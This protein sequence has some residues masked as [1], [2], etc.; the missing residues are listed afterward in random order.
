MS[1]GKRL[2]KRS[3]IGTRVCA[4]GQDGK[5]YSGV[6]HAVKTPASAASESGLSITPKTRYSVR[7]DSVPGGRPPSPSTEYSD[8]DLIGPGFGSVTSARLVPGQK[9]YLTY[10]GREIHAE[11]TQHR[12]HQDEVDVIIAPNG[13]ET[14]RLTK[15]IDEVRLLES[16]K[17]ARLAD[18]DTDF[19]RLADMAGDRKRASSHS[20][21][22]PHVI[23]SRKR[24][25]SSSNDSERSFSGWSERIPHGCGREGCRTNERG[26]CMDE[27]TA[28]LVLMS[29]SCSPHS[30]HNPLPLHCQHN[31][32]SWGGRG[33][34]GGGMV[35]GSPGVGGTSNSS[36]SSGASWRSGTPSPPLSDEGAPSSLWP[37]SAHSSHNQQHYPY[38]VSGSSSSSTPGSTTTLDEGI[39]PDYLEEQHPR[40]KKIR[41]KVSRDPIE[42]GPAN[43]AVYESEQANAA[44]VFKCTW[45]GCLEIKATVPL[46]EEHV[47][48]S[49]L[50]P[51]K[52]NS[53][54][55]EEDDDISDHEEEFYYQEVAVDHMSSPPTMSHRDMARPPHEDPE[56]QKQLRL[57]TTSATNNAESM[58]GTPI[59]HIKLSPRPFQAYQQSMGLLTVSTGKMPSSPR[60][61]RGETKKCRKVYGMEHR[62]LWCT[63][64]KWKKACSRFGD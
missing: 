48:Q 64:C 25:P 56:Y 41:A 15:R 26:D 40:K 14:M 52:T 31:Y 61:I 19:A 60:R 3:I 49:H 47:R 30:P 27:C 21:D 51:K 55:N 12:E 4:P 50:G 2:A 24:R 39:V 32:G 54:D 29:L 23:G 7:F 10:N 11:V 28:A 6:I 35:V 36:S 16:R 33:G 57:E 17:S 9:V 1:T 43:S 63:Q 37:T 62:D 46:I 13:Q 22:V 58:M 44:V 59:K 45:P 5:Y 34:G 38:N 18:Q 8:R 20:I 42:N 53:Y